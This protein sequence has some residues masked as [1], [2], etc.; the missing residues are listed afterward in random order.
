ME[1]KKS[2]IGP[3]E[4]TSKPENVMV[5]AIYFGVRW[6]DPMRIFDGIK[7]LKTTITH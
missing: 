4:R 2:P 7:I 6:Q 3:T 5:L 1:Y